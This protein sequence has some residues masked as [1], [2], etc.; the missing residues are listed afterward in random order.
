[1]ETRIALIGIIVENTDSAPKINSILHEYGEYIVGRMGV[2]YHKRNI[3]VISV[4]IDAPNDVISA[5]SGKLGMIP[6]VNTKTI[7]S[8]VTP[9]AE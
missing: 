7:Y 8:K 1:M 5:L 2:P 4:V 3:S 9:Q 6:G